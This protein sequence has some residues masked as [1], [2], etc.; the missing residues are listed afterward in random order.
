VADTSIGMTEE[1]Q[2]AKLFEE[3]SQADR[4]T[5]QCFGGTGF[6]LAVTRKLARMMGGGVTLASKPGKRALF[7]VRLPGGEHPITSCRAAPFGSLPCYRTLMARA[8]E[9]IELEN[10]L[11]C[12]CRLLARS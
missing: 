6:G 2:Q 7:T 4:I 3:F 5:A 8:D 1:Q 11:Q 12:E 9:V 10:L